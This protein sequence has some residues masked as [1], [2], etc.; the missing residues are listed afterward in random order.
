LAF[1]IDIIGQAL[2]WLV[3]IIPNPNLTKRK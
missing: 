3:S 1:V 2:L